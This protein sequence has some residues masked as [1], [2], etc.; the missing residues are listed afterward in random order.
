[1]IKKIILSAGLLFGLHS[2]AQEGTS[3]PYSYFG[4]GKD[5]FRGTQDQRAMGGLA[6]EGDSTALNL[7]NPASYSHLRLTAF[8]VGGTTNFTT[9]KNESDSEK[10]KRT[11]IDYLAVGIPMGKFGAAIG[12]MPYSSVGYKFQNTETDINGIENTKKFTGDGNI[13]SYNFV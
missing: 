9:L 7:V 1:M 4:L 6:I 5:R 8:A 3:S 13:N 10:A 11:T 2:C 12:L